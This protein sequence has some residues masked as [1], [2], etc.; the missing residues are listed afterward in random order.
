MSDLK[1]KIDAHSA[2]PTKT[3]VKARGFNLIIDGPESLGGTNEGA[4]PVEYVLAAFSGCINV[5]GH[6]I[7]KEMGLDLKGIDITVSGELNPERFMGTSF[8]ERAGYKNIEVMVN[9]HCEASPE[10]LNQWIREIEDRCPVSDNL[11][12][13]T[14]IAIKIKEKVLSSFHVETTY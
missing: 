3:I 9:P 11:N 2:N 4:N 8:K 1:F 7:A 13:E 14:P 6:V 10:L 5:M 12:H